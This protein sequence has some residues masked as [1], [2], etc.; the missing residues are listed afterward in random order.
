MSDSF[1]YYSAKHSI[2]IQLFTVSVIS[3]LVLAVL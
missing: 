1:E 3:D 2:A